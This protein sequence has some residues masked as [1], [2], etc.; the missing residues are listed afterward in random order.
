MIKQKPGSASRQLE[1]PRQSV[2]VHHP[3]SR[4]HTKVWESMVKMSKCQKG[5]KWMKVG[6][7][8]KCHIPHVEEASKPMLGATM[9][10]LVSQ[11]MGLQYGSTSK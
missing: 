6:K 7:I 9:M 11:S 3:N 2:R 10:P 1:G 4:A 8:Q 5:W